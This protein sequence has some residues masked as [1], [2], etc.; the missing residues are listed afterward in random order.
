[1]TIIIFVEALDATISQLNM[2]L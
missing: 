1:L 2:C